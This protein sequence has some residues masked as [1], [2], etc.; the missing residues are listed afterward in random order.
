MSGRGEGE[1]EGEGEV[2]VRGGVDMRVRYWRGETSRKVR[3]QF[4]HS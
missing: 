3:V 2:E 4:S 1:G